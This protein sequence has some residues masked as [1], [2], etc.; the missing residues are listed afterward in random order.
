[1]QTE[2]LSLRGS[3]AY[4]ESFSCPSGINDIKIPTKSLAEK[5]KQ[6]FKKWFGAK[7]MRD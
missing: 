3:R 4:V 1:M 5:K 6:L 7:Q 2:P